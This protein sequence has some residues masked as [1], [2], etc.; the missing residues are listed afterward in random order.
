MFCVLAPLL[1]KKLYGAV[2]PAMVSKSIAPLDPALQV[3]SV[4]DDVMEIA[5]GSVTV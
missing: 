4:V 2:P 3:T 5:A 1:H